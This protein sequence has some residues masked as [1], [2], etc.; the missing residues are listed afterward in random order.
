MLDWEKG[1]EGAMKEP[2]RAC[3]DG[4]IIQL[5]CGGNSKKLHSGWKYRTV[6]EGI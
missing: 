6:C 5:D 3:D 1:V 2:E 4:Q